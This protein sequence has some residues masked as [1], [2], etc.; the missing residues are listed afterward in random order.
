MSALVIG[1]TACPKCVSSGGD[2]S[3]NNRI[4]Y[5]DGGYHCFSCNDHKTGSGYKRETEQELERMPEFTAQSILAKRGITAEVINQYG[6]SAVMDSSN[7]LH[8]EFPIHDVNGVVANAQ[9][10]AVDVS[11]GT[12]TK[13]IAFSSGK[14]LLPLFGWKQVKPHTKTLII[15]E[16]LTD[17]L[18]L[19]SAYSRFDT[20][21]LGMTTAT[22]AKKVAA[23]LLAYSEDRKI[24]LAFDNDKAGRDA[25]ATFLN[26]IERHDDSR[27]IYRLDFPEQYKDIGDWVASGGF[28]K[29]AIEF[30]LPLSMSGLVGAKEIA[31]KVGAYFAAMDSQKQIELSFSPTLSDALRLMPG[32]LVGIIGASGEGK[33]TLVEHFAMEALQQKL[34]V[35]AVSQEMLAEEFAVKLLRMVRNEPLDSPK[36]IRTLAPETRKEI[37]QQTEKL[38]RL[39]NMTDGFGQ[40][41]IEAID[42]HL[43]KLTA[44]GRHPDLVIVDHLLAITSDSDAGTII[45]VC[46]ELK[47]LARNHETCVL[48]LTHTSKPQKGR[49]IQQPTLNS[50]Y[51]SSGIPIFCDSALGVA[52]DKEACI[53]MVETVKLERMGGAYANVKFDY[54]DYCLV[55]SVEGKRSSYTEEEED[56]ATEESYY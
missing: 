54:R 20:V 10:R 44:A 51:G 47:E 30:P 39:L 56:N 55:E 48:I 4:L 29:E 11:T 42:K 35:F 14:V 5:D 26:H 9:Y 31:A 53:T 13:E 18:I 7:R 41:S 38:C 15:C 24:V 22:A 34:N 36:F 23:H 19:A 52:S 6:V 50:A 40:M 2:R 33:S 37:V 8:I 1:S 49:G 25:E 16:G 43:H 27:I 32:K 28:N 12:M 17:A 45:E 46:R 3:G 21:V